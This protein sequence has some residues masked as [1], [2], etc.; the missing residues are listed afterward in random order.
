M[1]I[2]GLAADVVLDHA[3]RAADCGW[4]VQ[5]DWFLTPGLIGRLEKLIGNEPPAR[6]RPLLARLPSGTRYEHVQ[7]YLKCRQQAGDQSDAHP[8]AETCLGLDQ[9][10]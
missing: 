7:L 6:I 2:R 8:A 9:K 1:A 4:P 3:L 10:R 5:A